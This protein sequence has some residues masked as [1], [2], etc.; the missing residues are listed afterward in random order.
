[1]KYLILCLLSVL[2]VECKMLESENNIFIESEI[3]DRLNFLALGDWGGKDK[4]PYQSEIQLDVRDGMIKAQHD[5]ETEFIITLGDNFYNKGVENKYSHRFNTTWLQ[6]YYDD[7][8]Q[9]KWY[10]TQ[11]NHDH[12]GNVKAQIDYTYIDPT[13]RWTYPSYYYGVRMFTK[14]YSV[15][16]VMLDTD[17]LRKDDKKQLKWLEEVLS[18]GNDTYT[19]VFGH[20]C[21]FSSGPHG[22]DKKMIKKVRPLL[23]KYGV[24][25]YFNGHEHG[26]E[27]LVDE[28]GEVD[29]VIS[30][31]G[32]KCRFHNKD[33]QRNSKWMYPV[34]NKTEE[35]GLVKSSMEVKSDNSLRVSQEDEKCRY[36]G[37]AILEFVKE[38]YIVHY[39]DKEGKE[40]YNF[41]R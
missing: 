23:L 32:S 26:L 19:F 31:G 16:F 8:F 37:F 35:F 21:I 12:K 41:R 14:E 3:K 20:H 13:A 25:I 2:M 34:S 29:Y 5:L 24:D 38:G 39:Y 4:S 1:M 6:V 17:R 18:L 10:I 36:G 11:G 7:S 22:N 9:K 30:G 28:E 33:V 40:I 27:H 15:L